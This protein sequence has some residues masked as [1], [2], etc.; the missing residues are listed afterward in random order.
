MCNVHIV[1]RKARELGAMLYLTLCSCRYL[2]Y[3][4]D[5][6]SETPYFLPCHF[7]VTPMYTHN[8]SPSH[9]KIYDVWVTMIPLADCTKFPPNVHIFLLSLLK[10][11]Q[12]TPRDTFTH[13]LCPTHFHSGVTW[14]KHGR[15]SMICG[16]LWRVVEGCGGWRVD[17]AILTRYENEKLFFFF[18]R[19]T[20]TQEVTLEVS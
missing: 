2:K 17:D 20:R 1:S 3:C 4:Y 11:S 7:H 10:H 9:L 8:V 5:I 6:I 19:P 13:H 15:F 16:G 12:R 14:K 18:H